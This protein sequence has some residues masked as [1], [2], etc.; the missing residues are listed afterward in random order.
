M[1]REVMLLLGRA[2]LYL[3][4]PNVQGGHYS[5]TDWPGVL[6]FYVHKVVR[7]NIGGGFGAQRTD[8]WFIGPDS[9]V[10]H[11]V[12]RGDNDIVRCKRTRVQ[13][14]PKLAP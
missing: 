2:V 8:A 9:Y 11:A 10:W 12:N 14:R 5:V 4:S 6:R 1:E 3:A 7:R 13:L